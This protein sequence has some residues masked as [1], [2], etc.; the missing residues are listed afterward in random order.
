ML[1]RLGMVIA[2]SGLIPAML[3]VLESMTAHRQLGLLPMVC[4]AE[5][6][7][8]VG[9]EFGSSAAEMHG[10]IRSAIRSGEDLPH[11]PAASAP[12]SSMTPAVSTAARATRMTGLIVIS[13]DP[14]A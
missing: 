5:Q 13:I 2:T 4:T 1:Q 11:S 14:S 6:Q 7:L 10:A 9:A 3:A 8:L 12:P